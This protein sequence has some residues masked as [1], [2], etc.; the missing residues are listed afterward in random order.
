MSLEVRLIEL[1]EENLRAQCLARSGI[2]VGISEI[3]RDQ[4][5]E[6]D[7]LNETWFSNPEAFENRGLQGG[8]FSVVGGDASDGVSVRCGVTDET[9]KININSATEEIL[10]RV[11]YDHP[12]VVQAVLDWRDP[13]DVPR[14]GGG[15]NL[16]YQTLENPYE[17]KNADFVTLA[18]LELVRGMTRDLVERAGEVLTA[19]GDGRVNINTCTGRVL[20]CLGLTGD[21]VDA[22]LFIRRGPDGTDGTD[23]DRV[24]T[25]V[26]EILPALKAYGDLA[27]QEMGKVDALIRTG[28]VSVR[29]TCFRI[30]SIGVT[31]KTGARTE[32]S[33]VV[34]RRE[35]GLT[36]V[37]FWYES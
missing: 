17:C 12:D 30:K 26:E 34:E 32:I 7:S 20:E 6:Y 33:A 35:Q 13:D 28:I 4:S 10:E 31:S 24:F 8:T 1:R 19:H 23:D 5:P 11:F 21:I 14:S 22:I 16:Y 29:S 37:V 9:G 15:E 36:R 27:G 18:E 25:R 2:R 3:T